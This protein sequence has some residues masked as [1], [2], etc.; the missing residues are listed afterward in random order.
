MRVI[1]L[2]VALAMFA[3]TALA[4]DSNAG[5]LVPVE[6]GQ[7]WYQTCGSG[8]KAVVLIHDSVLHSA[9]WDDVWPILCREFH[10]VRY[11]RRGVGRSP[12]ATAS[13]SPVD[14][15]TAV[16]RATAIEH[17]VVVG[18]SSGSGLAVDFTLQHPTAVDRLVLVG[19]WVSG[20]AVSQHFIDQATTMVE[21]LTKGDIDGAL[22]GYRWAFAPGHDAAR[23][24]AIGVLASNPQ[25][26]PHDIHDSDLVRHAPLAK[27]LL[28]S[29]SVP[30]LILVG[31]YDIAD[32]QAQ[33][34]ALEALISRSKRIV[35]PD[36]GHL[37]YLEQ[38]DA[39]AKLVAEFANGPLAQ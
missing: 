10:V 9:T 5:V 8:P 33:V 30:T 20:F 35:L 28:A 32:V 6:A 13:Y 12:A 7:V 26:I 39:F 15:L 18:S 36:A 16:M 2:T 17:A 25:D 1:Y 31:E 14:D 23:K 37:M 38:P 22:R 24:K 29:I 3:G 34:G 11:D 19:P 4:Q 21:H 27:P